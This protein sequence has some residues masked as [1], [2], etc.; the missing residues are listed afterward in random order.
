MRPEAEL[1]NEPACLPD[2]D[3]TIATCGHKARAV[4]GHVERIDALRV[5][6]HAEPVLI[7]LR[8]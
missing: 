4:R 7:E 5:C 3:L 2:R 8:G 6:L 1:R